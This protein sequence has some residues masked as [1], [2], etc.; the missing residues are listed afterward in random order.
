MVCGRRRTQCSGAGACRRRT[1]LT[2]S[3]WRSASAVRSSAHATFADNAAPE[4]P[5][6][7][8]KISRFS[9][10]VSSGYSAIS[11][12]T[13]PSSGGVL[14]PR[15]GAVEQPD[16]SRVELHPPGNCADER[17]LA[18]AVGAEQREQLSLPQFEARAVEGSDCAEL[19]PRV[20]DRQHVHPHL[21]VTLRPN[22]SDVQGFRPMAEWSGRRSLADCGLAIG[23]AD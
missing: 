9:R 6:S 12:G 21:A 5:C 15:D 7:R 4:R 13:M 22:L 2:G 20:P 1:R 16:L 18:G 3:F 17:R 14:S 23:I 19:L 10:A 8:P 11:C